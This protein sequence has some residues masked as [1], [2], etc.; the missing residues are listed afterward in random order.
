I[1]FKPGEVRFEIKNFSR[2]GYFDNIN[3]KARAGEVVGIGGLMGAGR[4]EIFRSVFGIDEKDSGQVYIDNELVNIKNPSD[5]IKNNMAFLT[6]NRKEE[7]LVLG[8]SIRENL[9]LTNF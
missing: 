3:L 4:S 7:G 6:E 5:A 8:E 9:S 1:N 2:D